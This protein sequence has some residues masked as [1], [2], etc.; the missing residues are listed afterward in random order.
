[1]L[2]APASCARTFHANALP[3]TAR[4][5][6]VAVAAR[7]AALSKPA[8]ARSGLAPSNTGRLQIRRQFRSTAISFA[9]VRENGEFPNNPQTLLFPPF[10][11]HA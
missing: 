7:H 3:E 6:P 5:V 4:V 2:P 9:F 10:R 8:V 1:M 11:G